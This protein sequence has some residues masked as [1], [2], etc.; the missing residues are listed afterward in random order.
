MLHA[1]HPDISTR[2]DRISRVMI[3]DDS[4]VVR[5]LM[6][7]WIGEMEGFEVVAIA[8]NGRVALEA[9]DEAKPDIVL[10]DLDMPELDGLATLPLLIARR[11]SVSVIVVSTLTQRNAEISLRCLTLGAIDYLTKPGSQHAVATSQDFR[12][13]LLVRL[14]G[15]ATHLLQPEPVA[16]PPALPQVRPTRSPPTQIKALASHALSPHARC[17]V[18]GAS[19]GGPRAVTHLLKGIAHLAGRLPILLVQHMPPIFTTVFAEQLTNE[20]GLAAREG[21]DGERVEAGRVYIAPGGHHMGLGLSG[22]DIVI[23]IGNEA[24]VRHCRPAV[25]ILFADAARLYGAG[26]LGIVLTGMGNDGTG[27]ARAL[28]EAGGQVLVQDEATSTI[29]GMPGS[30]AKAGLARA[31]LPLDALASAIEAATCRSAS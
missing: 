16:Q 22:A 31:V 25:D 30:V 18:I 4:I 1:R 5:G 8:R 26:T 11:P 21:L 7:R 10:L 17:I 14:T 24:P 29:W 12:R 28:V 19:T 13:E 20:T 3:I 15:I 27:G 9:L 23:R 2:P 6:S